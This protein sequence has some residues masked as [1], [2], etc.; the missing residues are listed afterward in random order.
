MGR[1]APGWPLRPS[2]T[3]GGTT[4]LFCSARPGPGLLD[5][6][7]LP[8]R[9]EE[10]IAMAYMASAEWTAELETDLPEHLQDWSQFQRR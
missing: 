4:A 3:E 8:A 9:R 10:Y 5:D 6:L 2:A 7:G 1:A